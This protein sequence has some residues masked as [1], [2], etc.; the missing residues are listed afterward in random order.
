MNDNTQGITYPSNWGKLPDKYRIGLLL[1]AMGFGGA[2]T[3]TWH[4]LNSM[5]RGEVYAA[6]RE[7][8]YTYSKSHQWKK[9]Q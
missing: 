4:K 8:G 1:L 3:Y 9:G 2:Q 7:Y 6:L 5:T